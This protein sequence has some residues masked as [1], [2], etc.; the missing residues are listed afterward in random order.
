M[1]GAPDGAGTTGPGVPVGAAGVPVGA[2]VPGGMI[3]FGVPDGVLGTVPDTVGPAD[4]AGVSDGAQDGTVPDSDSDIGVRYGDTPIT[5][6]TGLTA[7]PDTPMPIPEEEVA[8][9]TTTASPAVVD[10]RRSVMP[11]IQTVTEVRPDARDTAVA[12]ALPDVAIRTAHVLAW[13]T[14]DTLPETETAQ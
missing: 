1:P 9:A 5:T 4:G 3:P 12:R 6:V 11:G 8:I 13:G 14:A 10:T 2:G 7:H